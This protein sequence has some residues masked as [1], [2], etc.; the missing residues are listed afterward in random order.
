MQTNRL[1]EIVYMLMAGK[2]VTARELAEHFEVS[3]RTIY[4]DIE[5]LSLA[6]IPVYMCQGKGGGIRILNT[7]IL[8]KTMLSEDEQQKIV[9]ALQSIGATTGEDVSQLLTKLNGLFQKEETQWIEIDYSDWSGTEK[10]KFAMVKQGILSHHVITFTYFGRNQR[11]ETRSV[12]PEKLY[13]RDRAWYLSGYCLTRKAMRL[14]KMT[15]MKQ[16]KVT[17]QEFQ[18]DEIPVVSEKKEIEIPKNQQT[19]IVLEIDECCGYRVY[20]EF[21][22]DE[23]EITSSHGYRVT[24]NYVVDDWVYGMILSY[25][26]YV[27][28]IEPDF[29]RDKIR[30]SLG[31][32]YLRY[33]QT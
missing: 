23:I 14:F 10:E 7:Y 24:V 12:M 18:R 25:G 32:A 19:K 22:E 15:R 2:N 17:E 20:D 1:F 29:V 26:Q 3:T 6:G 27:K 8:N 9:A 13:F 4:R 16:V 31:Q 30:E 21:L 33:E 11:K 5:A 28:V